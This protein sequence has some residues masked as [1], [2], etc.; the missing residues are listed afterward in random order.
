MVFVIIK[1]N[2]NN[3]E[4]Y[5]TLAKS[6]VADARCDAGCL[7]MEIIVQPEDRRHV[8]FVSRWEQRSDF[9]AHCAGNT[10]AKHIPGMT[11]YY[12]GGTDSIYEIVR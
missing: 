8:T 4:A 3:Q 5:L 6:F 1:N 11:P 10:F 12:E 7:G 2:V 9:E